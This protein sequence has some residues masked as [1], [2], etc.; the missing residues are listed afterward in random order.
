MKILIAGGNGFLGKALEKYFLKTN[1]EVII[2]TRQPKASN[3][4][5]WDGV[6]L[7]PWTL[8]LENAD[9]LINL[10]GKSVDC[11]YTNENKK[12]I[13]NS[14][15]FSTKI[16][17]TALESVLKPPKVWLNSSS[18]TIYIHAE[19]QLM[20]ETNEI[21]GD[22]FSMGVC[23]QWEN[24]FF[25][26]SSI[27]IRKIALRTSIVLG[28]EGGAFP[29]IKAVAKIGLGGKHG[30]GTQKMSWI[31]INDFCKAI[32][33]IIKEENI[34]GVVNVTSPNPV[35]N[36]LFMKIV[37]DKLGI[38]FGL[39]SP[40]VLLELASIFLRTETELLLKSRNVFPEKLIKK[41]FPFDF[42]KMEIALNDLTK[43]LLEKSN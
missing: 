27:N 8:A 3:H 36:E 29:K 19:T 26:Q 41:G 35:S 25:E 23:K 24:A 2:L 10:A 13:L 5:Y 38:K 28:S 34:T 37:R 40:V 17:N 39:N 16:L 4:I 22:D 31:H 14:R 12:E 1:N 42:P 9:V 18:A 30:N 33:F 15:L 21:L 6:N 11:R 20:S 32:A 7:G 43:K